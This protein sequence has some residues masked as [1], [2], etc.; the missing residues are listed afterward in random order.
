[1]MR[2]KRREKERRKKAK[3]IQDWVWV[4]GERKWMS[5]GIGTVKVR[6]YSS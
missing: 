5:G 3:G 6:E 4:E 2:K 1:M